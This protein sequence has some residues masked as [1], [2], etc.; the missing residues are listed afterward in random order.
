MATILE[1]PISPMSPMAAHAYPSLYH[2][3]TK[4]TKHMSPVDLSHL[5]G[6]TIADLIIEP[7]FSIMS[8]SGSIS[9]AASNRS[10]MGVSK[11]CSVASTTKSSLRHSN[12]LLVQMLQNITNELSTQR[13][14]MLDIQ[15]RVSHLEHESVN[16]DPPMSA[17]RALEDRRSKPNNGLAA[18][19]S[20]TWWEACQN[21]ARNSEEPLS[22]KEFLRTPKRFSGFDWNFGPAP[23]PGLKSQMN[24]PPA[25]PPEVEDL[26]PLTPTS[27]GQGDDSDFHM[28]STWD[29]EVNV[30]EMHGHVP[31][32][33]DV[34]FDVDIKEHTVEV[35]KENMPA[36]PVLLPAPVGKALSLQSHEV[37][38]AIQPLDNPRRYYMGIKSLRT[39]KALMK[40]TKSEKEHYV[41]IH[42]HKRAD[43]KHLE[44]QS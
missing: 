15:H 28:P 13:S 10:S 17:L 20:Q 29:V 41:L 33:K 22:A 34:E 4:D 25:T 30:E 40:N 8:A 44:D 26:P 23:G 9:Q 6:A 19:E 16:N 12:H 7:S 21:F 37:V 43:L 42:F 5:S 27:E 35:N 39:Y 18:P 14:I 31:E 1:T 3:R 2:G 11:R 32:I 36:A 38:N 24:T